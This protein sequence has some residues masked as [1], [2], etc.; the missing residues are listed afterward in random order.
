MTLCP[1][2]A[3]ESVR[4]LDLSIFALQF[5]FY[6][7]VE[8]WTMENLKESETITNKTGGF[9]YSDDLWKSFKVK[10]DTL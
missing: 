3:A 5:T 7:S 2:T 4:T 10:Y 1:I 8:T 9:N 6:F